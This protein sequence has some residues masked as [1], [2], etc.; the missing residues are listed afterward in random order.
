MKRV[1][2]KE[3]L[4]AYQ[5]QFQLH[6]FLDNGLLEYAQLH[7]YEKGSLVLNAGEKLAYYYLL[8]EGKIKIHYAFENGK[9][10]LLKFYRPFNTIGD[11]ELFKGLPV[12]CNVDAVEDAYFIAIPLEQLKRKNYLENVDF[13]K[14]LVASLSDKLYATINNSAYNGT[15]PLINRLSSYLLEYDSGQGYVILQSSYLEIA[16]FLGTTYRHLNRVF[17]GMEEKGLIQCNGK[18]IELLDIQGLMSLAQNT[19]IKPL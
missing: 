6:T 17:N 2:S 14:H 9:S 3:K 4:L 10:M 1:N 19:Y 7:F 13:L 12:L 8:V 15:Y 16:Q 11:L 18:R 5:K